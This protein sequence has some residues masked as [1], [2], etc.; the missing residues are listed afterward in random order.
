[1]LIRLIAWSLN[2]RL[3]VMASALLLV[4][5]GCVAMLSLNVDAFPDTTPVQVQINTLAPSMV[6]EEVERSVTFPIELALGGM[7]GLESMR[8][9]SL[10]GISQVVLT[11]RDGTNIYFARQVVNERLGGVELPP[12]LPR[13]EM[14]PVSTGL[15]EVFQYVLKPESQSL[16]EVRTLQD[17]TIKPGLRSVPGIAELNVWGGFKK[18]YQI[19]VDPKRLLRFG[20]T[21]DEVA[22]VIPQNNLNVGGGNIIR[23]G[24]ALLVHGI[25]R[26]VNEEQIGNIVIKSQAGVPIRIRDVSQVVVGEELRRGL[27]TAN[28]QGEVVLGIGYMML[29]ENSYEVTG[30]LASRF[31]EVQKNIPDGVKAE[32]V[33]DRTYL[34]GQVIDTVRVNLTEGAYF[35]VVILFLLLGNLRAGLIAAAAIPLSL[36][37]GFCGMWWWGIAGSLL[38]LGAIDFGIVVDS[39]VVVIESI[40]RKLGHHQSVRGRERL[41]LI[42]DAAVEV[43]NP[44][45][46]GQLIIMI[47]YLPILSL[48]GVEGKM[49]R[50]MALTVIFILV[51]SLIVS[52]TFTPVL[53]SFVLPKKVEEKESL[54][55]RI[56]SLAYA[57]ALRFFLKIRYFTLAAA[58]GFLAYTISIGSRLGTEFVPRL[59]EGDIVI[60]IVRAAGTSLERS[61]YLNTIMEKNLLTE[62]PDEIERVWTRVGTPEVAT[63]VGSMESSD[64]FLSLKPRVMW[65]KAKRQSELAEKILASIDDIKGQIV[66]ITQPIEQRLNEMVSGVRADVAIKLFG[67]DLD[68]LVNKA[69][70]LQRILKEVRGNADVA[71]EQVMGQPI[72]RVKIDQEAIARYGIAA[73]SVLDIIESVGGKALGEVVEGQLRFPLVVR[74]PEKLRENAESIGSILI[75]GVNGEQIPLERVAKI[76]LIKGPKLISREWGERR[77]TVQC[78]VRGRDVGSFVAEA[79]SLIASKLELPA[80]KFRIDWGGQFENMQ[81]AQKRLIIVVPLALSLILLLLYLSYRN[82]VDTLIL[83]LSVPFATI[84]GI[85]AL[86]IREMPL[87]IPAAVGFITLSGVSVLSSMVFVSALREKLQTSIGNPRMVI[88]E[89][90]LVTMRTI[91]MT[92]LVASV[93]FIPMAINDAPG[94]EVQ[95]P[96]AS[97]VIGG[98]LTATAFSL[99]V[100]PA[101]YSVCLRK[102]VQF[103]APTS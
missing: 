32:K 91:V 46:F 96:L 26:T 102:S 30:N 89:T 56:L 18:Q 67:K 42:K 1:M 33:Y 10:F 24:D 86:V 31:A 101:I 58:V 61:A 62:F 84:G 70:E 29:G 77:I 52:L 59:S 11:F 98:V 88:T 17:W 15:G 40:M 82:I 50:P 54:L 25:G 81:R 6:P 45:V 8:S 65:K 75:P 73:Q 37:V 103:S 27:V 68:E 47:V 69:S 97:V 21:F 16:T 63:E 76:E 3:M 60:G 23:Q 92:A 36:F 20:L 79:Q 39:S 2:H 64:M 48:E 80:D 19:R 34:V 99:F 90:S 66:W 9:M 14:G 5:V 22:R 44:A 94:A 95:R 51:G 12:G 74:L 53:A 55:V 4:I 87:S 7:K 57:P 28:G 13:P 35:V 71:T 85:M 100:L 93:G 78:N 83:F 72:L 38:S 43:R 41:Q 49:F